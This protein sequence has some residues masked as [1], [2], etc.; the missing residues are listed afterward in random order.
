MGIS[1]GDRVTGFLFLISLGGRWL[2][3]W[4]DYAR[5]ARLEEKYPKA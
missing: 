2:F 1:L 4:F 3:A 5:E